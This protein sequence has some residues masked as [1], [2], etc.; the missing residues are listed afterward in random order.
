MKCWSLVVGEYQKMKTEVQNRMA[1]ASAAKVAANRR[2]DEKTYDR[3]LIIV[4]KGTLEQ[5][6]TAAEAEG[7]SLNRYILEALEEKSGLKLT[8][9]GDF[10]AKRIT[11]TKNDEGRE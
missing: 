7:V 4:P 1:K 9:D 8:L 10:P 6:K 2:Y 3:K 11:K 5:L